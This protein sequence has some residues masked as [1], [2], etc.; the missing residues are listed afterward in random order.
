MVSIVIRAKNERRF[1]SEVLGAVLAQDNPE[2]LEIVVID[3]GSTDGTKELAQ[4][5]PVKF[6]EIPADKFTFGYALNYGA[7]QALGDI[8]V[9]L[10]AH[11]TPTT[12]SWL[13]EL[14]N[15]LRRN[16]QLVA[17]YGRQEPRKGVNPFE[18]QGLCQAFPV[19]GSRPPLALFSNANCAIWRSALEG[20]PFDEQITFAEDLVW[21]LQFGTREIQYVPMASVYHSHPLDLKY[22]AHRFESDGLATVRMLR[23]YGITNPYTRQKDD[24]RTTLH[25]FLWGCR[26]RTRFLLSEGYY[27]FLAVMPFFEAT[28]AF[29][30]S[31]GL[32]KGRARSDDLD[33]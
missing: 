24:L 8:V 2:E 12:H 19:N 30:F 33:H 4:S 7:R 17:T 21:R 29:C 3:S 20:H 15:P 31:R 26:H 27:R 25:D 1:L 5:F 10:S 14:V 13:R 18:E 6:Y 23:E 32:R 28:R 22:W 16:D 11:C 9:Y